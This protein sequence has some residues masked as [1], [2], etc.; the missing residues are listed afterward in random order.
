MIFVLQM[1]RSIRPQSE[2]HSE[3]YDYPTKSGCSVL[4]DT[5]SS[6]QG[7]VGFCAEKRRSLYYL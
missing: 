4:F 7:Y 2:V 6:L 1:G 3:S 5:K